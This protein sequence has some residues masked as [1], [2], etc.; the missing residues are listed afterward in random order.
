MTGTERWVR[1]TGDRPENRR[2]VLNYKTGV[3]KNA[4][5]EE[6]ITHIPY[7]KT[8]AVLIE[9]LRMAAPAML[10]VLRGSIPEMEV[11]P[12]PVGATE[13]SSADPGFSS[14]AMDMF[15]MSSPTGKT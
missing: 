10:K 9:C 8:N 11:R 7:G 3:D 5:L 1:G 6:L 13:K 2:I 14:A 12:P 4:V 15:D